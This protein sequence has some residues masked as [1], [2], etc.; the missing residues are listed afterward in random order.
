MRLACSLNLRPSSTDDARAGRDQD[1]ASDP[2]D[3]GREIGDLAGGLRVPEKL[4]NTVSV[5]SRPVVATPM[6]RGDTELAN[7]KVL[8]LRLGPVKEL[9]IVIEQAL[10]PGRRVN[11]PCSAGA[12]VPVVSFANSPELDVARGAKDNVSVNISH[13]GAN[14]GHLQVVDHDVGRVGT[15]VCE[16][17]GFDVS[18]GRVCFSVRQCQRSPRE[19]ERETRMVALPGCSTHQ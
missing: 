17:R 19:A 2:V 8:V 16:D 11:G 10:G 13:S 18:N 1:G 6:L 15:G 7:S 9:A 3:P 12:L 14:A 5:V 4:I